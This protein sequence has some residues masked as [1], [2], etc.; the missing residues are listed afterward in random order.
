MFVSMVSSSGDFL[1]QGLLVGDA[2]AEAL[3]GQSGEFG[4]GHIEPASVFGR[5]VPFEPLCQTARFGRGEGRLE[6]SWRMRAEIVLHEDNLLGV[7]KLHVGQ[8]LQH[9][10]VIDGGVAVGDLDLAPASGANIMNRLATPLR[11]Y[12]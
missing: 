9:L 8:F 11:S 7:G 1:F 12:W 6:R 5:V 4:F 10:R 3:A 2:A